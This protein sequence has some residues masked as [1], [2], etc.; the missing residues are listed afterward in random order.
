MPLTAARLSVPQPR[1]SAK[2]AAGLLLTAM[3]GQRQERVTVSLGGVPF[4][5]TDW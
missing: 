4:A 1:P 2:E 5:V 3:D